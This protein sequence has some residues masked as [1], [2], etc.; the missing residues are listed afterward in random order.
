MEDK[1][2]IE[3]RVSGKIGNEPLSPDNYDIR[4]IRALFDVI[5]AI[6]NPSQR[7]RNAQRKTEYSFWRIGYEQP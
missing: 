1:G 4:E 6:V 3:I 5:E 7:I 2:Q